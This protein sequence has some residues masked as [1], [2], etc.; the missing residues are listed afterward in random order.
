MNAMYISLLALVAVIVY[1]FISN[2]RRE[3]QSKNDW[4]KEAENAWRKLRLGEI[5]Y[6]K[7]VYDFIL[8][9]HLAGNI[10]REELAEDE[11]F[12][13]A[14][15]RGAKLQIE[16]IDFEIKLLTPDIENAMTG[17]ESDAEAWVEMFSKKIARFAELLRSRKHHMA[18]I[19]KPELLF[20]YDSD[21][22]PEKKESFVT[23]HENAVA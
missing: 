21:D 14:I 22:P 2:Q 18:Y 11:E 9:C 15:R 23:K 5:E 10:P 4:K 20:C 6:E 8:A 16:S 12:L 1:V 3:Q 7:V 13:E 17:R 19:E